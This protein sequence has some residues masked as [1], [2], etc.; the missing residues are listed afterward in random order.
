MAIF[1]EPLLVPPTP[2]LV[3]IGGKSA[4][5]T[6]SDLSAGVARIGGFWRHP[7]YVESYLFAASVLVEQGKTKGCL[8][9]ICLPAFYLQR[10]TTEL[11]IKD[12]LIW[13]TMISGLREKLNVSPFLISNPTELEPIKRSHKLGK[14]LDLSLSF[15]NTLELPSPPEEL[16]SLVTEMGEI[17]TT[18]TWARYSSSTKPAK[19]NLPAEHKDH[20]KTE[21]VVPIVDFQNR[22]NS[23][24]ALICSRSLDGDSYLDDLQRIWSPLDA[25]LDSQP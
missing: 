19:K 6:R 12:I 23:I 17:E 10:H 3:M 7:S 1:E 8:D 13:L 11:L 24:A 16:E 25:F 18:D 20:I 14:L 4:D 21:I 22:L 2:G 5:T 15:C 9:E